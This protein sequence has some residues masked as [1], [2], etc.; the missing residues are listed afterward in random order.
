[1]GGEQYVIGVD[2]GTLS[3]RALVV[4][5]SDGA[6]VGTAV[7]EYAHGVIERELPGGAGAPA[8]LGAPGPGRLRDGAAARGPRGG[9]RRRASTRPTWSGIGTDFTACT[10]LPVLRRRHA[11]VRGPRAARAARTPGV[12][13]WKHHAAQP[14]ADRINELAAERGET[15]ARRATAGGSPRSGSSRRRCSCSRRTRSIYQR[16]DRWVEAAD[17]IVW[18]LMRR[19]VAQRLHRRLQGDLPGRPLPDGGLPRRAQPGLRRLRASA[20]WRTAIGQLGEPAGTLTAAGG[21]PGPGCPRASRSPSATST[22]TS[23]RPPPGPSSP[24]RCSRSWAPRP[25]T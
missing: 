15:V 14:Q 24:G 12:K 9:A 1:M 19:R 13:L 4:R 22:R 16:M 2:F 25:A 17:W 20:S 6:E 11:A 3:G 7:T 21:R 18:Q 10:V 5:V 8:G 23:P